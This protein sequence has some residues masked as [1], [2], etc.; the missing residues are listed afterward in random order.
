VVGVA[1]AVAA[2]I[3]WMD[4]GRCVASMASAKRRAG[5]QT[6]CEKLCGASTSCR[7]FKWSDVSADAAVNGFCKSLYLFLASLHRKRH[8]RKK[9]V[10]IVG[11]TR[12]LGYARVDRGN[13]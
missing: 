1:A 12:R 6:G 5:K 13:V 3:A 10:N 4:G 8:I 9:F 11:M 2:G 7:G